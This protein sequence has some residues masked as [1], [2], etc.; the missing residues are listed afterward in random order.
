MLVVSRC[1]GQLSTA[2]A[3]RPT[4]NGQLPIANGW[5]NA[6]RFE[7]QRFDAQRF[8]GHPSLANRFP[9]PCCRW[10]SLSEAEVP[11]KGPVLALMVLGSDRACWFRICPGT[12]SAP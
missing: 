3:Q 6:E 4:I 9:A 10:L 7:G 8:N 5:F 11:I 1:N 12:A 2:N